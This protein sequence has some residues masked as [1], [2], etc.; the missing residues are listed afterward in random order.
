MSRSPQGRR[1]VIHDTPANTIEVAVHQL[2]AQG[3]VAFAQ[4]LNEPLRV[5]GS[6][7]TARAVHIG[8]NARVSRRGLI[9]DMLPVLELAGFRRG[10]P[11]TY[12]VV[13]AVLNLDHTT[14]VSIAPIESSWADTET[15]N[16]ATALIA[17]AI[18]ATAAAYQ[19]V[20]RLASASNWF[21]RETDVTCPGNPR[22]FTAIRKGKLLP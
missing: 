6:P 7:W 20:G 9:A 2:L 18:D 22:I 3:F 17:A 8:D 21:R 15:S 1:L 4:D 12:V 5:A 19:Q 10:I 16:G 14:T 11:L 13:S